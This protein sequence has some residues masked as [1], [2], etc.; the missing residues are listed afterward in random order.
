MVSQY[1]PI[2]PREQAKEG[3]TRFHSDME[4]FVILV[5]VVDSGGRSYSGFE[6]QIEGNGKMGQHLRNLTR[7]Q[8]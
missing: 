2:L 8:R 4:I 1:C 7:K 3:T 6:E 5:R